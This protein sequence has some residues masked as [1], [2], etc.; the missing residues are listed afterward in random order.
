MSSTH[1]GAVVVAAPHRLWWKRPLDLAL[2]TALLLLGLPLIGALALAVAIESPG[3]AFFRQERVGQN[4]TRFRM[5]KLRTMLDGC[6]DDAHRLA[7]ADWFAGQAANGDRYK[8]LAD[9]RVTRVG[10][11][12]RRIDLDELPQLFNVVRGEM[13]LVG[14]RPAIPYEL[15][16]YQ[17]GYLE[18]LQVTP[19]M[20]GLWQ[21]TRRDR[22]SAA[23]MMELDLRYVRDASLWL[24]LR[25]LGRTAAAVLRSAFG[26][27]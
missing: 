7:A 18:R 2:G 16:L 23:G 14:P 27:R 15:G 9:P 26:E 1:P 11:W 13:S 19:G 3:P 10:R 5:W 20:T 12:L 24:D 6:P 25:V 17:P 8:P 22:L 21:V 4:G